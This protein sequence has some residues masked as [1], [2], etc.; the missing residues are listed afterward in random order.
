MAL[1]LIRLLFIAFSKYLFW[2]AWYRLVFSAASIK[3]S[4]LL[5]LCHV[6]IYES[7]THNFVYQ[8]VILEHFSS[9][10]FFQKLSSVLTEIHSSCLPGASM[11][12]IIQL[13]TL[14]T[15]FYVPSSIC[16]GAIIIQ[17]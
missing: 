13:Y 1:F 15:V 3:K 4:A 16:N 10:N 12:K 5:Y 9:I 8:N 17:N 7:W 14:F 2:V 11:I 6:K